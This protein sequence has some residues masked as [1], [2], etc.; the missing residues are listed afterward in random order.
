MDFSFIGEKM[1]I[2][3][4]IGSILYNFVGK[5]L[6]QSSAKYALF[7]K[8]F[9]G[10]CGKLMLDKI[11]KNVNIESGAHF[12]GLLEIGD[13]SGIGVNARLYGKVV[14]G[15]NVLMGPD[16]IIFTSGHQYIQKDILIQDQGRTEMSPVVIG[17]DVWIGARVI[18]MPG[19]TIGSGAVIGAGAIVT[20]DVQPYSV[21]A[22]VPARIIK[23]RV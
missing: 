10:L 8:Q 9:R 19:I 4:S 7:S 22:G 18:I 14:I 16:V 3:K 5:H 15:K 21:M 20:K 23:R 17:D 11:G 12:T 13:N 6:P 2:R 1:N